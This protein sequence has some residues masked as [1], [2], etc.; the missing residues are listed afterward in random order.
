MLDTTDGVIR[1]LRSLGRSTE[2][3]SNS[4]LARGGTGYSVDR[5]P[6][7]GGFIDSLESRTELLNR[8]S[9]LDERERAVL[10]LWYVQD[11]AVPSICETLGMSRATA[12]RIRDRALERLVGADVTTEALV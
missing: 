9:V 2:P 4:I 11:L 3:R 1:V 10:S 12:Y 5:D 6:F 8:F 7:F